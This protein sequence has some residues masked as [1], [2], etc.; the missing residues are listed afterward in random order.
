MHQ[1]S[2]SIFNHKK[3]TNLQLVLMLLLVLAG[4]MRIIYFAEINAGP[5]ISQHLWEETDMNFFDH[6]AKK[7]SGGD[8]LT[9][10][11]VHPY[12][13]WH[14]EIAAEYFRTNPDAIQK[15]V[16][17]DPGSSV[18]DPSRL[19][20]NHW[21]GEKTFHQEPLYP[22]LIAITYKLF[23]SD[24]RWVFCWQMILGIL[25][26]ALIFSITRRHF[27][28]LVAILAVTLAVLCGPMLYYEMILDRSTMIIFMTLVLV[29]LT[30]RTLERETVFRWFLVGTTCGAAI[31]LKSTFA[32]YWF[33]LLAVLILRYFK[34]PK[35]FFR[36]ATGLLVGVVVALS[37]ALVR[38]IIVGASPLSISAVGTSTFVLDNTV[39]ASPERG[40]IISRYMSAIMGMS[41][42]HIL[43]AI[44]ETIRT[45]SGLLSYF[46]LLWRKFSLIF[47]WYEIPDNTNYYLYGKYASI[48]RPLLT[49]YVLGPLS[50]LGLI[51]AFPQSKKNMAYPY[52]DYLQCADAAGFPCSIP[53]QSGS[54]CSPYSFCSTR[55]VTHLVMGTDPGFPKTCICRTRGWTI[56]LLDGET[57]DRRCPFDPCPRLH[58]HL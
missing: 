52:Y 3:K 29:E 30:D 26:I 39:D 53:I 32:L 13:N 18:V 38:N 37:P 14:R 40:F 46:A 8:W 31:L 35:L 58:G 50:V 15:Y 6:W 44:V 7:I 55:I 12:N 5:L 56:G 47:H 22:Y 27:G 11:A 17:D 1:F 51:L 33:G 45:H 9:D 25:N 48:L 16:S 20:W 49:F 54:N 23:G 24:V 42:G 21:Y 41:D 19:L 43:P 36:M 10:Q 28:D 4:L 34:N 57:S 2:I